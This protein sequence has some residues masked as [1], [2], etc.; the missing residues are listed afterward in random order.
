MT[1][2]GRQDGRTVAIVAAI[3]AATVLAV[4]LAVL[5]IPRTERHVIEVEGVEFGD[6]SGER[7][8]EAL[9]MVRK[10]REQRD[11]QPGGPASRG[12]APDR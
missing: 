9:D 1:Q 7:A 5:F 3:A 6:D 2:P 12:Y 4:V 8:R 11:R 10:A